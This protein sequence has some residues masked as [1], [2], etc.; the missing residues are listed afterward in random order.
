MGDGFDPQQAKEMLLPIA[1]GGA[2]L[3]SERGGQVADS[4][5]G[6]MRMQEA[7]K[8]S[9][10]NRDETT[11]KRDADTR[12]ADLY[13]PTGYDQA[14]A[15][16]PTVQADHILGKKQEASALAAAGKHSLAGAAY[17]DAGTPLPRRLSEF[18]DLAR[19]LPP[20]TNIGGPTREGDTISVAG[21]KGTFADFVADDGSK[22]KF[23]VDP[24]TGRKIGEAVGQVD[25]GERERVAVDTAR[26]AEAR[27]KVS[28]VLAILKGELGGLDLDIAT[29][30]E[31][32]ASGGPSM[33]VLTIWDILSKSGPQYAALREVFIEGIQGLGGTIPQGALDPPQAAPLPDP[34][35]AA[36]APDHGPGFMSSAAS[37]MLGLADRAVYGSN[38]PSTQPPAPGATFASKQPDG[39]VWLMPDG[40]HALVPR[41]RDKHPSGVN[42]LADML[43]NVGG[44]FR[45]GGVISR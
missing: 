4:V 35:A 27:A 21:Q 16:G 18:R 40:Q 7:M 41:D 30:L 26:T 45:S 39:D 31:E 33:S 19:G 44:A 36:V 24:V 11:R 13:A 32:V 15:G 34:A 12:L 14:P 37:S 22:S 6:A 25:T 38:E 1:A 29:L 28:S 20:G 3:Y 17:D 23:P 42:R 8:T 9:S 43:K 2:S 10:L 5:L